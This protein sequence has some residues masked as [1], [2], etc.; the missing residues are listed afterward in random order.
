MVGIPGTAVLSEIGEAVGNVAKLI[1]HR[2]NPELLMEL[3]RKQLLSSRVDIPLD[4][5]QKKLPGEVID[6]EFWEVH[7]EQRC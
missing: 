7:D 2:G 4:G 3:F 6:A 5:G 1:Q